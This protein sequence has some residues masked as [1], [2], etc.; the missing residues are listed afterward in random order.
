MGSQFIL[1]EGAD[2]GEDNE[3]M[4]GWTTEVKNF[5]FS[6]LTVSFTGVCGTPSFDSH[7]IDFFKLFLDDDFFE[8]VF[9]RPTCMLNNQGLLL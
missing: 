4:E 6:P 3:D 2:D 7:P 5:S 8:M 1:S 9:S